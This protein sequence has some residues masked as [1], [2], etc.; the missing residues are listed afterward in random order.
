MAEIA[1]AY[2]TLI[3]SLKGANKAI[4]Q[5][6]GGVNV[7]P[8]GKKIGASLVKGMGGSLVTVGKIGVGAIAGIGTAIAGIAAA[9]GISRALKIDQ[10]EM[11]FKALGLN[12]T[13][14]MESC[15][16]AV[17][18]TAFG[19]DAAA[20]V[21]ASLGASGVKAG[22][23][24]TN[25][26]KAVAGMAA[27]GG[28]SMEDVGLIFG[29]VAAQG[30]LQGDELMQFAESG[31]NASAALAKHLGVTGAEVQELVKKGKIDFQTFSDAM[32]AAFGTAAE[33]ANETFSGAMSNARAALSRIGAKFATPALENLRK[34]FV[35]MIPAIDALSGTLDPMVAKFSAFTESVSTKLVTGIEAF[36]QSL[37]GGS[38]VMRA[39]G[40]GFTAMLPQSAQNAIMTASN[41]LQGLINMFNMG[42]TPIEGFR[43]ALGMVKSTI[44]SIVTG[45]QMGAFIEGIKA[46]FATLPQP[47]QNAVLGIA[48]AISSVYNAVVPVVTSIVNAVKGFVTSFAS[49]F[50]ASGGTLSSLVTFASTLFSLTSPLG[51]ARMLFEQFGSTISQVLGAAL[52]AAAPMLSTLGAIL[53]NLAATL[54]PAIMQAVNALL[55][56][57]SAIISAVGSVLVSVLPVVASLLQQMAPVIM[58]IAS[59]IAELLGFLAPLISQLV[60]SLM[61]VIVQV[62]QVVMN[63]VQA[64]AP[65]VMSVISAIMSVI[66]A[67]MPVIQNVITVVINIATVVASV[68]GTVLSVVGNVVSVVASAI[69]SV[70]SFIANMLSVV[71]SVFGTILS[72]VTSVISGV[73]S[74]ISTGFNM[75]ANIVSSVANAIG[76]FVS[77]LFATI[78]SVFSNIVSTVTSACSNAFNAAKSAFGNIVTAV[79]DAIGNVLDTLSGL[80]GKIAGFFADAGSWLLDAGRNIIGGL[81]DGITGAIGGLGDMLGNIGSFIIEHKGPP[82]YDKVMLT[83]N[84]ELIMGGLIRGISNSVPALGKALGNVTDSVGDWSAGLEPFNDINSNVRSFSRAEIVSKYDR[85]E[86]RSAQMERAIEKLGD[87]IE[88]MKVVMDSGEL[89]GSTSAKYDRALSRRQRLAERGF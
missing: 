71:A 68:I 50:G 39:F 54:L 59:F 83:P 64:V 47:I 31:I 26:L 62:V 80:P 69:G 10:A 38:G 55:P 25:S 78:S 82:Q 29:K 58:Q 85:D 40:A 74:F 17:Q 30:R 52:S 76:S 63:I 42:R 6:L 15:N 20:T 75:A 21:A 2:V 86:E 14:V 33:G 22:D 72:V 7:A 18:G 23:E 34:V 41:W 67:L 37:T 11:K 60:S 32:Y 35:S 36:T 51:L 49:A 57:I 8:A 24:M 9:G 87:R 53:G 84:G 3:P 66:R 27:M 4:T 89:V 56:A 1:T 5:Q 73:V 77:N 16:K 70:I 48:N 81:I 45:D 13:E 88:N 65:A 43:F 79:S 61:P 28:R 44:T 12:V 46:K 19:L